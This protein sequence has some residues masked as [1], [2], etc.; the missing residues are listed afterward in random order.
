MPFVNFSM[1]QFC[2]AGCSSFRNIP[3]YFTEGEPCAQPD[4]ETKSSECDVVGTSAHQYQGE[5]PISDSTG[6]TAQ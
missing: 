6:E 2:R 5:T 1:A 3:R 4:E